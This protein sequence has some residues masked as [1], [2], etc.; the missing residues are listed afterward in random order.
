MKGTG[1]DDF[2]YTKY[3]TTVAVIVPRGTEKDFLKVYEGLTPTVVPRSAKCFKNLTDKDGNQLWRVV[4]CKEFEKPEAKQAQ[5]VEAQTGEGDEQGKKHER[6]NHVENF[7]RAL[8]ERRFVPRDFEYS[9]EGYK[10][11]MVQR[12][13]LE[14]SVKQQHDFVKNLYAAAWSDAMVAWVHIKAMRVFVESVLRFG[15]PPCFAS[16]IITPKPSAVLK[17]RKE[18]ANILGT[19]Q[20]GPGGDKK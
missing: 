2:I 6:T 15:M 9:E 17:A 19:G 12:E 11:L 1:E 7:K 5:S 16:F 20:S 8:R 3:L 10:K 18:L 13:D 4:V 14:K